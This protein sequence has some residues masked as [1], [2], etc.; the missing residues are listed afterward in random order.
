[1]QNQTIQNKLSLVT[2]N[3]AAK[4]LGHYSQAVIHND[5]IYVS[6]Q[7]GIVPNQQP[8]EVGSIEE[9]TERSLSNIREILKAAGSNLNKIIKVTI[10]ISNIDLWDRV[11]AVYS[12]VFAEHRPARAIIPTKEL[13]LGFQVAIDVIA[14]I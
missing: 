13:H 11:N 10:Y 8:I 7:L 5:T 9:Q 6:A 3:N 1:M 12:K 4:P 14:A 2:T